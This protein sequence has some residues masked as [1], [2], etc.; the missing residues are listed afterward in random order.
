MFRKSAHWQPKDRKEDM[1]A[2]IEEWARK[3]GGDPALVLPSLTNMTYRDLSCLMLIT[4]DSERPT[5]QAMMPVGM[6]TGDLSGT[7]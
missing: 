1:A 4:R 2:D 5:S 3:V 7:R 6:V